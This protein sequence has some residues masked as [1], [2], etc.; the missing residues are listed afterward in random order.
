MLG[1]TCARCGYGANFAALEFHHVTGKK[2][3]E[4]DMRSLANRSWKAV[5]EAVLREACKCKLLC[6]NCHA[7]IHRP[8]LASDRIRSVIGA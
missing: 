4:L 1:G 3:F 5:L 2:S 8:D 6:S 7:E